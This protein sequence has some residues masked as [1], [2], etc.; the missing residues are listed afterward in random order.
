MGVIFSHLPNKLYPR[1]GA[2][3]VKVN[4]NVLKLVNVARDKR[5]GK[6]GGIAIRIDGISLEFQHGFDHLTNVFVVIKNTYVHSFLLEFTGVF[7]RQGMVQKSLKK[8]VVFDTL[9]VMGSAKKIRPAV[10]PLAFASACFLC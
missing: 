7:A 5:C 1:E 3:E 9:L 8:G 4:D 10:Y 6:I 2:D